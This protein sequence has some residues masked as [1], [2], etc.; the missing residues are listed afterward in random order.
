VL[1]AHLVAVSVSLPTCFTSSL[2]LKCLPCLEYRTN[3]V[4]QSQCKSLL[5]ISLN[6]IS[7]A[8]HQ[9]TMMETLKAYRMKAG[10]S[11][12]YQGVLGKRSNFQQYSK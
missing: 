5:Y 11:S 7:L 12:T 9:G 6:L 4:Q 2:L 3:Y 10:C 8:L 1:L